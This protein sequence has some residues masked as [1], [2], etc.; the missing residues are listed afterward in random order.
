MNHYGLNTRILGAKATLRP[1]A[2]PKNNS[3]IISTTTT[4]PTIIILH[5]PGSYM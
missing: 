2:G 5:L 1:V 4:T 3:I